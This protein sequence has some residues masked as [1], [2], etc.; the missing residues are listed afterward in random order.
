MPTNGKHKKI[1]EIELENFHYFSYFVAFVNL[2]H[3]V[4]TFTFHTLKSAII[5]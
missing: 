2:L 4:L 5:P 3:F 1:I